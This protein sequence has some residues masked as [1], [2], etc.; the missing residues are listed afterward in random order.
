MSHD[1]INDMGVIMTASLELEEEVIPRFFF[2]F[3][4]KITKFLSWWRV[5][6]QWFKLLEKYLWLYLVLEDAERLEGH[7]PGESFAVSCVVF[8]SATVS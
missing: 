6:R 1:K 4:G 3:Q 2:P 5:E 8:I 7:R